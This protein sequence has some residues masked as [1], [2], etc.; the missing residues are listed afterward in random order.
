MTKYT[1]ALFF[2]SQ[3]HKKFFS[4]LQAGK[5]TNLIKQSLLTKKQNCA[6]FRVFT[7]ITNSERPWSPNGSIFKERM[8]TWHILYLTNVCDIW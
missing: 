4:R 1:L 8:Y 5:Q 2:L 7:V 3:K 6:N